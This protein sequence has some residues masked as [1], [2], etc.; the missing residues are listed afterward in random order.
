MILGDLAR[1]A[2]R[3]ATSRTGRPRPPMPM[4]RASR[5]RT[6]ALLALEP[7]CD[8]QRRSGRSARWWHRAFAA[9]IDAV[10]RRSPQTRI[11]SAGAPTS[12]AACASRSS[13]AA[14]PSD[15]AES[16]NLET[17]PRLYREA[18]PGARLR[19]FT[20]ALLRERSKGAPPR[21]PD[22]IGLMLGLGET[23]DEVVDV[24][25]YDLRRL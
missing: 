5:Q 8:L 11:R 13:A 6:V 12:T 19:A 9:C 23:D 14:A 18:R 17:V 25:H 16:L 21:M 10:R 4:N 1:G 15:V 7:Y 20:L 2:A 24:M 3:S 22:E